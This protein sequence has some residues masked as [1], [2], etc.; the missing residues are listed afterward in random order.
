MQSREMASR[1]LNKPGS[2]VNK[3]KTVCLTRGNSHRHAVVFVGNGAAWDLKSLAT[4][5]SASLTETP[6]SLD[7]LAILWGCL[8]ITVSRLQQNTWFF[9]LIGGIGMVQNVYASAARRPASA[10]NMSIEPYLPLPTIVG[11]GF[12]WP[13]E[14]E[15]SIR[16]DSGDS[17]WDMKQPLDFVCYS[18]VRKGFSQSWSCPH[19]RSLSCAHQLRARK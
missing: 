13:H 2:T 6:W 3:A 12:D 19:A 8:L 11:L 9:V 10:F 4:A 16:L 15:T 17:R 14:D 5:S 1:R 18:T 7:I